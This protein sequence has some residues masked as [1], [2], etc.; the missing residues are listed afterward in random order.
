M[1]HC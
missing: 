1:L